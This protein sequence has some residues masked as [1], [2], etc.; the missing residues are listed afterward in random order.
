LAPEKA[1]LAHLRLTRDRGSAFQI[2]LRSRLSFREKPRQ[3]RLNKND[4]FGS[5]AKR[6]PRASSAKV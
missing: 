1:P 3:V 5:K 4:K 6:A 2:G